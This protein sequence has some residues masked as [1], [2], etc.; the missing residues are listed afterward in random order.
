MQ[1]RLIALALAGC[2]W[3]VMPAALHAAGAPALEYT[4]EMRGPAPIP[5]AEQ[6][7]QTITATPWFKVSDDGLQLEVTK[8]ND[9]KKYAAIKAAPSKPYP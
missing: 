9:P 5:P 7:L 3:V 1:R 6:G 4:A 8:S 2:A